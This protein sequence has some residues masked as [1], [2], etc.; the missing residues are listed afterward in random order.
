MQS[1]QLSDY[2]VAHEFKVG[3]IV[4]ITGTRFV[5]TYKVTSISSPMPE[6][7]VDNKPKKY[8]STYNSKHGRIW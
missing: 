7:G 3:D 4:T 5:G 1:Q 8:R 6:H 2:T